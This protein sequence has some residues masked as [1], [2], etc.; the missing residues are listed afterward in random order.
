MEL[1][2][3]D[4]QL[5]DDLYRD[6]ELTMYSNVYNRNIR[7]RVNG[8]ELVDAIREYAAEHAVAKLQSSTNARFNLT[9]PNYRLR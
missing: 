4:K 8:S 7:Q 5:F 1:T 9:V 6:V 2:N 3:S